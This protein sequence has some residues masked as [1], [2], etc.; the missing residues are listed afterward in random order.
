ME[1]NIKFSLNPERNAFIKN[2]PSIIACM[3]FSGESPNVIT[4]LDNC[5][6]L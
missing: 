2:F 6:D 5:S 1:D 4:T 3:F